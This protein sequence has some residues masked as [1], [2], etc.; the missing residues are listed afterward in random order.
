MVSVIDVGRPDTPRKERGR[1][2]DIRFDN[3]MRTS[4]I[5]LR[6]KRKKRA[7]KKKTMLTS[8]LHTSRELNRQTTRREEEKADTDTQ[9]RGETGGK[10]EFVVL[11][12]P[13]RSRKEKERK[14]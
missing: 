10:G 12:S 7:K 2:R 14:C 4:D 8:I 6:E 3:A 1:R 13:S 9:T 11:S 5:E